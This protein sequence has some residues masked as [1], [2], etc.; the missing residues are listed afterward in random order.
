MTLSSAQYA[1]DLLL[2]FLHAHDH[3]LMIHMIIEHVHFIIS[4]QDLSEAEI[5]DDGLIDSSL[6]DTPEEQKKAKTLNLLP[7]RFGILNDDPNLVLYNERMEE[8]EKLEAVPGTDEPTSKK[9]RKVAAKE[10][11]DTKEQMQVEATKDAG[12]VLN[13]PKVESKVPLPVIS[14]KEQAA[15]LE[16]LRKY[17]GQNTVSSG[18]RATGMIS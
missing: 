13:A 9:M 4:A 6:G 2:R 10:L 11:K 8:A 16:E 1:F 17:E 12:L 15:E 5:G 3:L 14:D 18:R 7:A